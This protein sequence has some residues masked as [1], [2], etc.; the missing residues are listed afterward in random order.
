[1]G[2][3][4]YNDQPKISSP[5]PVDEIVIRGRFKPRQKITNH[6]LGRLPFRKDSEQI[7]EVVNLQRY[8]RSRLL[9]EWIGAIIDA[10]VADVPSDKEWRKEVADK[11]VDIYHSEME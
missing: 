2:I 5:D 8:R 10:E 7:A 11:Q 6:I 1:M 9:G 4:K 3:Y